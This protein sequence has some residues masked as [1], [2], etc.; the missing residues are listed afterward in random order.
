M[1]ELSPA[2][3]YLD[4][5]VGAVHALEEVAAGVGFQPV[6]QPPVSPCLHCP[7]SL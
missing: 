3:I 1:T 5:K 7:I 4:E 6:R 2:A